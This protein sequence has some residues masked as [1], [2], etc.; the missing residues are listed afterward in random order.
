MSSELY[1]NYHLGVV[2]H[3]I[4]FV[5]GAEILVERDSAGSEDGIADFG[6]RSGSNEEIVAAGLASPVAEMN[7]VFAQ[8]VLVVFDH[9]A[10]NGDFLAVEPGFGG[11]S[12]FDRFAAFG[13]LNAGNI[14][15]GVGGGSRDRWM[16]FRQLGGFGFRTGRRGR[17]GAIDGDI[18]AEIDFIKITAQS[19]AVA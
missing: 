8:D 12:F 7:P 2:D 6:R 1:F 4:I 17:P 11:V 16:A 14:D 5:V 13:F 18:A 9:L 10:A 19:F 15:Q 3:Q